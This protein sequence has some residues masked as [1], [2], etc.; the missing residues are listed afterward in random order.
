MTDGPVT[1]FPFFQQ[2]WSRA[3]S[4]APTWPAHL[5]AGPTQYQ[6]NAGRGPGV[7]GSRTQSA[8]LEQ[9]LPEWVY[10]IMLANEINLSYLTFNI[11][12]PPFFAS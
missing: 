10:A 3:P 12:K 2:R 7:F 6:R 5:R 8:G 11:G 1:Y 4:K 9:Q